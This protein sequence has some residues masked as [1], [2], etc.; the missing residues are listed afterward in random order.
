MPIMCGPPSPLGGR[1]PE[2]G[3]VRGCCVCWMLSKQANR[4]C[5]TIRIIVVMW[6]PIGRDR[7][8]FSSSRLCLLVRVLVPLFLCATDARSTGDTPVYATVLINHINTR[9][10]HS[11]FN[12][13]STSE[14]SLLHPFIHGRY[15]ITVAWFFGIF[16]TTFGSRYDC[17][18]LRLNQ[19]LSLRSHWVHTC[20]SVYYRFLFWKHIRCKSTLRANFNL[21]HWIH[22]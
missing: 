11:N 1:V 22:I 2:F 4:G 14:R 18:P 12:S 17:F 21:G 16:Q 19:L 8:W 10:V 15:Y 3:V 13:M 9:V 7:Q 5:Y 6:I 20:T